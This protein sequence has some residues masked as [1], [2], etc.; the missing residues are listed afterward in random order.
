VLAV[1]FS[2]MLQSRY[3]QQFDARPPVKEIPFLPQNVD[4]RIQVW[5]TEFVP[6]LKNDLVSGY[7]PELPSSLPFAYTESI[8]VTLLWRGG[9]PLLL[10]YGALMFALVAAARA[11]RDDDD[12]YRSVPARV[13]T[14]AVILSLFMQTLTNYFVNAGFPHLLWVLAALAL[15]REQRPT[16][17]VDRRPLEAGLGEHPSY[18]R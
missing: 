12:V 2:P 1:V 10:L 14:I 4:F 3:Q 8:Y 11:P 13:V 15:V 5:S 9:L 17:R 18:D 16:L 6:V 7:G